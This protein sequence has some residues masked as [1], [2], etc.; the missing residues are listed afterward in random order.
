M[1]FLSFYYTR[2]TLCTP[3]CRI[4]IFIDM[5]YEHCPLYLSKRK[6]QRLQE[7][8]SNEVL[9]GLLLLLLVTVV[10]DSVY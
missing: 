1:T 3:L 9:L 7:T 10:K 4:H 2:P 5:K 6:R 8:G